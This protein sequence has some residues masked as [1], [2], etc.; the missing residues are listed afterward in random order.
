MTIFSR[1]LDAVWLGGQSRYFFDDKFVKNPW[2]PVLR[3]FENVARHRNVWHGRDNEG[4][5]ADSAGQRVQHRGDLG[6]NRAGGGGRGA[7]VADS[8]LYQ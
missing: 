5:G 7:G 1:E 6:T 4:A 8:V 3:S 2:F